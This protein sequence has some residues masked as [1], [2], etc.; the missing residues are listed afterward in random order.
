[1]TAWDQQHRGLGLR[2][3][4]QSQFAQ[5]QLQQFN[6]GV[7][8][9]GN[10]PT[11]PQIYGNSIGNAI[12]NISQGPVIP[13]RSS[14]TEI[15]STGPLEN[16]GIKVGEIYGWRMWNIKGDYLE[17]Y[18]AG[19]IWAP[20]EHMQGEV[21]DYGSEG[22]WSFKKRKDAIKKFLENIPS[23]YGSI[24]MWGKVV[25]HTDGYRAEYAKIFRIEDLN[26]NENRK[27]KNELLQ[28]IRKNYELTT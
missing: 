13:I 5:Q 23:A 24:K 15:S 16:T 6:Q 3:L 1:M 12:G 7:T 9:N 8:N 19:H 17:S 26:I 21:P 28:L 18:S 11:N 4:A 2:N 22:I 10:W 14:F 25:E 20:K 27:H